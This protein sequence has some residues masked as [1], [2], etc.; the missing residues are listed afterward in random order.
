MKKKSVWKEKPFWSL[1]L[2]LFCGVGFAIAFGF[3]IAY[4]VYWAQWLFFSLFTALFL[5][6]AISAFLLHASFS[7]RQGDAIDSLKG[8]DFLLPWGGD[9]FALPG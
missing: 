7:E 5:L 8:T 9:A 3:S 4:R 2:F 6:T 1:L